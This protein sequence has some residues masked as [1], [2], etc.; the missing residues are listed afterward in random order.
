MI[1]FPLIYS[2]LLWTGDM[3]LPTYFH[4]GRVIPKMGDVFEKLAL[5]IDLYASW[6]TL[7]RLGWPP[8]SVFLVSSLSLDSLWW[9]VEVGPY[10]TSGM[11]L[12]MCQIEAYILRS[13]ELQWLS[14]VGD[15]II[16]VI[17]PIELSQGRWLKI[18]QNWHLPIS[19]LREVKGL[20][21]PPCL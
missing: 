14:F 9:I 2:T 19:H 17:V 16:W 13:Y 21:A 6:R 5:Y 20:A 18:I 12:W 11:R 4:F 3:T 7:K 1:Q 15:M 10:T 8:F